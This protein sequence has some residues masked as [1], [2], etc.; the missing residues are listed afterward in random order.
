MKPL[1]LWT[2]QQRGNI[3]F[4]SQSET[5]WLTSP[6]D[7]FCIC[8]WWYLSNSRNLQILRRQCWLSERKKVASSFHLSL[9]KPQTTVHIVHLY[10]KQYYEQNHAL[11]C[12]TVAF[13]FRHIQSAIERAS[14][15]RTSLI[16][17]HRLSTIVRAEQI[18]VM[19][20]VSGKRCP[21]ERTPTNLLSFCISM[22]Q[23]WENEGWSCRVERDRELP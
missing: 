10:C 19:D 5:R 18:V 12:F 23:W 6:S 7:W 21:G 1:L 20:Q 16:V 8:F 14:K 3:N 22:R 4:H 15:E 13:I 11:H 2:V 9:S 17:A